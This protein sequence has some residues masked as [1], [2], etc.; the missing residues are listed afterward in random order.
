MDAQWQRAWDN[1][2]QQVAKWRETWTPSFGIPRPLRVGKLDAEL[3]DEE[4]VQL[5]QESLMKA[6]GGINVGSACFLCNICA[7]DSLRK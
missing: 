4:L 7:S 3:L 6:L 1:A 2:A 5:L